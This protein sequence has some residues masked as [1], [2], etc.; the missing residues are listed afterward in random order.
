[1][2]A[3][4]DPALPNSLDPALPNSLDPALPNSLDPALPNSLDP[5]L[6]NSFLRSFCCQHFPRAKSMLAPQKSYNTLKVGSLGKAKLRFFGGGRFFSTKFFSL[7]NPT[8]KHK[9]SKLIYKGNLNQP[10]S[11]D[12]MAAG[13]CQNAFR[14]RILMHE[15]SSSSNLCNLRISRSKRERN[16]DFPND[17]YKSYLQIQNS[18]IELDHAGFMSKSSKVDWALPVSKHSNGI[19]PTHSHDKSLAHAS[20]PNLGKKPENCS[21]FPSEK[22]E[23]WQNQVQWNLTDLDQWRLHQSILQCCYFTAL[24]GCSTK[25]HGSGKVKSLK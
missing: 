6:P 1:M 8:G 11:S 3:S 25:H 9:T 21:D 13:A 18:T 22:V 17:I 19:Y 16:E 4:F 20:F 5:A 7:K 15:F 24:N 2:P 12:S 23:I 14:R 10:E